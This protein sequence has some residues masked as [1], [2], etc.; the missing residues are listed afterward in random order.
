MTKISNGNSQQLDWFIGFKDFSNSNL[1]KKKQSPLIGH[2][3]P[4]IYSQNTFTKF[5][6]G[7]QWFLILC[8]CLFIFVEIKLSEQ[9][10]LMLF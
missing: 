5:V 4:D 8:V 9:L 7:F 10:D 3:S 2:Y 6:N 1:R